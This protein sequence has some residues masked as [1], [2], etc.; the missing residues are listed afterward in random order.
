MLHVEFHKFIPIR[1]QPYLVEEVQLPLKGTSP[2][3][4]TARQKNWS[5]KFP[6]GMRNIEN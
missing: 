5:I 4:K 2:T 3:K 6:Q 1:N